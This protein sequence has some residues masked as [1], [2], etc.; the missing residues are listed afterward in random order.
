M[1]K[2]RFSRVFRNSEDGS[3]ICV[4]FEM[5]FNVI[6]TASIYV[7]TLTHTHTHAHTYVIISDDDE[8]YF[9]IEHSFDLF[10]VRRECEHS[11]LISKSYPPTHDI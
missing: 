10:T 4:L 8:L 2:L 3:I 7:H 6:L 9:V 1:I 5:G 11:H